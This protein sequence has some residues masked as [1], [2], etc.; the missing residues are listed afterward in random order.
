MA[1]E[2]QVAERRR[3]G[4]QWQ[5]AGAVVMDEARQRPRLR[6]ER[7]ARLLPLLEDGHLDPARSQARR[8]HE[9][10]VA[11]SHDHDA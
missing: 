5:N 6:A 3:G 9:P 11:G 8:A 1:R 10:G 4:G 7:S 2:R